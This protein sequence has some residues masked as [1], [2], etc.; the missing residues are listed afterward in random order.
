VQA[1]KRGEQLFC[2]FILRANN[3]GSGIRAPVY[4]Y[5]RKADDPVRIRWLPGPIVLMLITKSA[6][7]TGVHLD[8]S[9]LPQPDP[10]R[11]KTDPS[12]TFSGSYCNTDSFDLECSWSKHTTFSNVYSRTRSDTHCSIFYRIWT[13]FR[14]LNLLLDFF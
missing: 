11:C 5:N 1:E 2:D 7:E 9:I 12:R 3:A 13:S 14:R 4:Q 6:L 10:N 8:D